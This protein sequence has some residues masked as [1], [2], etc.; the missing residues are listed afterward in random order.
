MKFNLNIFKKKNKLSKYD[1]FLIEEYE[2]G[3]IVKI[4]NLN[5]EQK[6]KK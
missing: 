6:N 5:K 3:N 4:K 1:K 2:K